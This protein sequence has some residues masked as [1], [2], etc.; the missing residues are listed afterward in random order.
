M[1]LLTDM[2]RVS[3][4]LS[5]ENSTPKASSLEQ[6]QREPCVTERTHDRVDSTMA[7]LYSKSFFPRRGLPDGFIPVHKEQPTSL[8]CSQTSCDG[9]RSAQPLGKHSCVEMFI[10]ALLSTTRPVNPCIPMHFAHV[11][12]HTNK[13]HWRLGSIDLLKN[14]KWTTSMAAS[15]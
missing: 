4:F 3:R 5:F 11:L 12:D 6:D 10:P 15:C 13:I 7:Y 1:D 9:K 8:P 14:P 2:V